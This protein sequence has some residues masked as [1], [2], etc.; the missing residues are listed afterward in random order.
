MKVFLNPASHHS[1][2]EPGDLVAD[3]VDDADP[4][5]VLSQ[6]RF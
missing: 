2:T 5:D 1:L 6:R 3:D 4:A